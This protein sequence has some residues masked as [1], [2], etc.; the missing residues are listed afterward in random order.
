MTASLV[1]HAQ[2][3]DNTGKPLVGGLVYIGTNGADPVATAGVTTIF[4]D[5]ALT[6]PIANPQTLGSDGRTAN[7]VWVSGTYS[8]QV[9]DSA[10]VQFFQDLDAGSD[11]TTS[12]TI[13]FVTSVIGADTITGVTSDSLSAY[14]SK[15]QFVFET[16]ATNTGAVTLNVD[17]V[18][19]RDVIKNESDALVS[20]DLAGNQII[21][22]VYNATNDNFEWVNQ[23]D[24][25][26]ATTSV[27]GV[28]RK[29]TTAQME[30]GA[31]ANVY[32]DSVGVA[33][34]IASLAVGGLKSVQVFTSSGTWNRPAGIT[35][36][37]IIVTGA[38]EAGDGGGN[39]PGAAGATAIKFIDVSAISSATLTVGAGGTS[40]GGAGGNSVWADGTNTVTGNGGGNAVSAQ[41]GLATGGDIN[42]NGGS[43]NSVPLGSG[44]SSYY[45]GGE[46]STS[47]VGAF[48]AGGS[49]SAAS[50]DGGDGVIYIEEY[51]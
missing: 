29:A 37:K 51:A 5:R 12:S 2:Y 16:A 13:L 7:K 44:A 33:A 42:I 48:G 20:G 23:N 19:P 27:D 26:V 31:T 17:S 3:V 38:G 39:I 18:G 28:M 15:Q 24:Q 41:G 47:T 8:I 11:T 43:A 50:V 36:V 35:K 4:S 22:V 1:E 49:E 40:A 6:V 21:I 9:N 25:P 10:A 45:G 46:T 30:G 14:T 34:A 32:G